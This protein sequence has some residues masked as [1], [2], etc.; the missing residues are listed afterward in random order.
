MELRARGIQ[1]L[2]FARLEIVPASFRAAPFCRL[3][4][5]IALPLRCG[6][7]LRNLTAKMI[8]R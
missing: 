3:A 5:A 8:E 1:D 7:T 2:G 6:Q 4:R